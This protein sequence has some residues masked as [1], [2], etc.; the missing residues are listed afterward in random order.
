MDD[1]S[2]ED[3]EKLKIKS[4][5][6]KNKAEK[7]KARNEA[8]EINDRLN[9]SKIF[10]IPIYQTIIGGLAAGAF[11][12]TFS[13]QFLTPVLNKD[14]LIAERTAELLDIGNKLERA[15][16]GT[17][18]KDATDLVEQQKR[19]ID[20]QK[21]ITV[22]ESEKRQESANSRE[23]MGKDLSQL[24]TNLKK[25]E[26]SLLT[27]QETIIKLEKARREE[28]TGVGGLYKPEE[29]LNKLRETFPEFAHSDWGVTEIYK[30]EYDLSIEYLLVPLWFSETIIIDHQNSENY[31]R[32][33]DQMVMAD[34]LRTAL[35]V[36]QNLVLQLEEEKAIAL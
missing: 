14:A 17:K 16:L 13:W 9:Q 10:G 21:T 7:E 31:K 33:L 8:A 15:R 19:L 20:T 36:L 25:S 29:L 18:L 23:R 3:L 6:D 35:V 32:Q 27:A 24:Q 28:Q 11:I 5:I 1:K 34:S 22:A 26:R 12:I 30:K 2:I 4:E